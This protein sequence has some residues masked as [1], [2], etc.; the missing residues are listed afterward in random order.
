LNLK[1][2]AY[3]IN[4]LFGSGG[5]SKVLPGMQFY[6]AQIRNAEPHKYHTMLLLLGLRGD[7]SLAFPRTVIVF[8]KSDPSKSRA[9]LAHLSI[10]LTERMIGCHSGTTP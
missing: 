4:R 5:A 9:A 2:L 3:P 7:S 10:F 8:N 1:T 6:A